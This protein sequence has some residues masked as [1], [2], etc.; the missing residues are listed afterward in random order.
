MP[1]CYEQI[2]RTEREQIAIRRAQGMKSGRIGEELGR[3]RT[4]I[5]RELRRNGQEDGV[6]LA[7]EA[8]RR[9]EDRRRE[10]RR[11]RKLTREEVRRSV[12]ARLRECWSPEQIEGRRRWEGEEGV[13]R[14]TIYRHVKAHGEFRKYLRGPNE[15]Q[16]RK[17]Q[18]YQRIRG[19]TMIEER[20]E[21]VERRERVGDW[22]SDTLRGPM[23]TKA[24]VVTHV[25]R[26][27]RYTVAEW[28]PDREARTLNH[29]TA[30]A[31]RGLPVRTMTVD[32][33]ME[34]GCFK[35][36]EARLGAKVYFAHEGCPWERGLNENTNRL[37][38]QFFPRGTDF[39]LHSPADVRRAVELLNN[40]PRKCLGYQTPKEAMLSSG[41]A[42]VS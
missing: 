29:V 17:R 24:G 1:R 37:L 25:D 40:R 26:R 32:N 31:M 42:L 12:E 2:S 14:M 35:E 39:T 5:W 19:R 10:P 16:R 27:T 18:Q 36:L 20:P 6:Y 38:R 28:L 23:S 41:V 34:F 3:A 21:E 33:G 15:T 11:A 4:T 30:G 8:Q 22:E 7:G 9:A 13:S